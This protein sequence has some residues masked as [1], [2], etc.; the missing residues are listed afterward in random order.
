MDAFETL[1]VFLHGVKLYF[2][3][4]LSSPDEVIVCSY[5]RNGLSPD[6]EEWNDKDK[7]SEQVID[8]AAIV[9]ADKQGAEVVS[10][11][12]ALCS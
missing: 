11:N 8:S 4:K 5:A 1:C 3:A 10:G 12:A 7:E 9:D 6:S 2:S